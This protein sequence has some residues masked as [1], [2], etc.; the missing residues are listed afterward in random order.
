MEKIAD[1]ADVHNRL[2][3][4]RKV[5]PEEFTA[6]LAQREESYTKFDYAPEQPVSSLDKG[7]YYLTEVDALE[8]RQYAR[9]YHTAAAAA[10]AAPLASQVP[11]QRPALP[12]V[13]PRM[14][15]LMAPAMRFAR[16]A[17]RR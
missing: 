11:T 13:T 16:R 17:L 2:A 14:A 3:A 4:R 12:R 9:A 1:T 15:S 8:R 7:T 6:I 5:S 10:A